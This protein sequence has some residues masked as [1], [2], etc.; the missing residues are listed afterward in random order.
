MTSH[1]GWKGL[2]SV[3]AHIHSWDFYREKHDG[4]TWISAHMMNFTWL[5]G[6]SATSFEKK[7]MERNLGTRLVLPCIDSILEER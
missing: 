2:G 1:K 7:K 6:F 5:S 4:K 3:H